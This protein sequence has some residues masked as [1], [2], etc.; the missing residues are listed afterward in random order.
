MSYRR[1]DTLD[2]MG[3][4]ADT[5]VTRFGSQEFFRALDAIEAAADFRVA[6]VGASEARRSSCPFFCQP[7]GVL[8]LGHCSRRALRRVTRRPA[9]TGRLPRRQTARDAARRRRHRRHGRPPEPLSAGARRR[10]SHARSGT[11]AAPLLRRGGRRHGMLPPRRGAC[12]IGYTRSV[13][14][15]PRSR[16]GRRRTP[17]CTC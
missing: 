4:P 12:S 1:G 2:A 13:A 7:I 16:T 14:A 3:R 6:L 5:L 15:S 11:S 10:R 17:R 8:H 9:H